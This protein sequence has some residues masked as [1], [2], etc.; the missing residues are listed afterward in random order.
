MLAD[1]APLCHVK[2][3]RKPYPAPVA[4]DEPDPVTFD[5]DQYDDPTVCGPVVPAP[6]PSTPDDDEDDEIS[7]ISM[8]PAQ[9]RAWQTRTRVTAPALPK[10]EEP[11]GITWTDAE[12]AELMK[13]VVAHKAKC[14]AK[15]AATRKAMIP[16]L[17][18]EGA[19]A[20]GR[21]E[22]RR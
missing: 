3:P 22:V 17:S 19:N 5:D 12:H 15:E 8:S 9:F 11:E 2:K 14:E 21:L 4:D 1:T 16:A 20:A 7:P 13:E 18:G 6:K 10:H